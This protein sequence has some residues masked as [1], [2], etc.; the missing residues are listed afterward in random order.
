[1]APAEP[2]HDPEIPGD[3]G[4]VVLAPGAVVRPGAL[5]FRQTGSSGP[6]G[7]HVNK[8][9]TRAELR[10][11]LID[12]RMPVRARHRLRRLAGERMTADGVLILACEKTRSAARNRADCLERLRDLCR[13]ALVEPKRRIATKPSRGANERRLR[14]KRATGERKRLRGKPDAD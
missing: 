5:R 14:A 8:R 1:M 2:Q 9:Q 6:G 3:A 7:Q 12:I 10:V 13:R 11:A 4:V